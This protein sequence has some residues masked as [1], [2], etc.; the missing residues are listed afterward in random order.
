MERSTQLHQTAG[1]AEARD[2]EENCPNK[3]GKCRAREGVQD[4]TETPSF[5]P[6]VLLMSSLPTTPVLGTSHTV[7]RRHSLVF[8][9][10]DGDSVLCLSH[11]PNTQHLC[12]MQGIKHSKTT[13]GRR[14]VTRF[15]SVPEMKMFVFS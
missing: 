1:S 15:V 3:L 2:M 6:T 9:S 13:S 10:R 14:F 5:A 8:W 11:L 4:P 7:E 12:I